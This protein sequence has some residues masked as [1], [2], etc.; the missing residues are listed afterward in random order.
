ML[1]MA[2]DLFQTRVN[3]LEIDWFRRTV[4]KGGRTIQLTPQEFSLL[5]VLVT[6]RGR[7]V[8]RSVIRSHLYGSPRSGSNTVDV[9]VSGLR[10][11][12]GPDADRTLIVTC[13]GVGY[14]LRG[15][16]GAEASPRG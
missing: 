15:E 16:D 14:M 10:D 13:R 12:L 4:R 1:M 6:H 8:S 9:L 2:E 3:D 11:K 7:P 5:L